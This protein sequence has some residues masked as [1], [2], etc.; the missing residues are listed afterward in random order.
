MFNKQGCMLTDTIDVLE[1]QLPVFSLGNDTSLRADHTLLL[2]APKQ[3]KKYLWHDYS[4][5]STY[6]ARSDDGKPGA[7]NC[8]LSVTD[9]LGCMWTDT[10]SIY[11]YT[12]AQWIDIE[13]VQLVTYPNPATDWLHWYLKTDQSCKMVVELVDEH[14]RV[15]YNQY[16]AEYSPGELMKIDLGHIPVGS[17]FIRLKNPQS[18]ESLKSVCIIKQ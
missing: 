9:S 8:W 4:T 10:I 6:L 2:E 3:Y 18:G 12:N 17:Y 11:Y 1:A 7:Y 14:G 16:I 13:H 5:D 15:V